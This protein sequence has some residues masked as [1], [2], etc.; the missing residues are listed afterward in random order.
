MNAV[1]PDLARLLV[2][3]QAALVVFQRERRRRTSI[4]E[5][6]LETQGDLQFV[7]ILERSRGALHFLAVDM[8][9]ILAAGSS[10]R[11]WSPVQ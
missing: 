11:N 7:A 5:C 1:G 4:D 10:A 8:R 3:A 2:D 6:Q 9:P